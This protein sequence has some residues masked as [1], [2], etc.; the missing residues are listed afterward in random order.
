M[1]NSNSLDQWLDYIDRIHPNTIEMGL[2]RTEQVK[3]NLNLLPKCPIVSVT[4]TNG[5]GS[6][7]AY[8]TA[9]YKEA[10]FK[11]GTLTSPHLLKFNERIAINAEAVTDDLIIQAFRAIEEARGDILL[12][13]F[14]FNTLAAEWV[15]HQQQV[16]IMNLEVG[17]GGRLDA[18]NVFDADC[19]ILTNIDLD[20]QDYLGDTIEKIGYEKAGI[21]R[22][23]KP[24]I[25]GQTPAPQSVIAY[26]QEQD[27][28][29]YCLD[30]DFSCQDKE[31]QWDFTFKDKARTSLPLPT[32]RGAYQIRNASCALA[33]IECL[34]ERIPVDVGAI[35]RGLLGAKNPGRFQI[36]PGKPFVVLDVA[37]NPHAARALVSNLTKLPFAP[38][39]IAVFSMLADKDVDEVIHLCKNSF[40]AWYI[41]PL[42]SPRALNTESLAQKLKEKGITNIHAFGSIVKAYEHALSEAQENDRITVFGSF[43]TVAEILARQPS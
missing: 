38:N 11:T 18:I 30:S 36:M 37:H 8:L 42:D 27:I 17:L 7:C 1:F 10:G 24:A 35:K 29:L 26:C 39:K 13:Y 31:N 21:F 28:P 34:N 41:A 22:T 19:A 32:L 40:D 12:T 14:E 33:A 23:G 15:F 4:G 20:H 25:C 16:D 3:Q 6:V 43:F 2:E 9:I 5:K